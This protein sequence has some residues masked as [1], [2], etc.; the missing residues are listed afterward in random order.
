[1]KL[2]G[3]LRTQESPMSCRAFFSRLTIEPKKH[4]LC[5]VKNNRNHGED[6]GAVGLRILKQP[7]DSRLSG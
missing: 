1:M 6:Y 5:A 7:L 3:R 4:Y 2:I